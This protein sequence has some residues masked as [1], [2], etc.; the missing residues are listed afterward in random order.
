MPPSQPDVIAPAVLATILRN[1]FI[2]RSGRQQMRDEAAEAGIQLYEH[3]LLYEAPDDY[4]RLTGT[5]ISPLPPPR[6]HPEVIHMAVW[7][8][9]EELQFLVESGQAPGWPYV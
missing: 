2:V 4:G 6:P 9:L 1:E 3:D 8:C 7:E 5:Q